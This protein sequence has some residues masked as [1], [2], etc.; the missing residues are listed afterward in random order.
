MRISDWSSD[1][2]SSDLPGGAVRQPQRARRRRCP[3]AGRRPRMAQPGAARDRHGPA[4]LEQIKVGWNR[5]RRS[6][7]P[8]DLLYP[9]ASVQAADLAGQPAELLRIAHDV[10]VAEAAVAFVTEGDR[11]STRLNSSH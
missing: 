11:K 6:T 8:V 4:G 2:C 5:R 10:D 9:P 7:D 3:T 1:V